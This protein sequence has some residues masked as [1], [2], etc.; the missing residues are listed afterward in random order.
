MTRILEANKPGKPEDPLYAGAVQQYQAL[1]KAAEQLRTE[2]K[3]DPMLFAL[4]H[5]LGAKPLNMQDPKEFNDELA[6]RVG[7]ART[8]SETYGAPPQLLSKD[9]ATALARGFEMASAPQQRQLLETMR[10][11]IPDDGAFTALMQQIRPDS[12]VVSYV[13]QAILNSGT[14]HVSSW[15]GQGRRYDFGDVAQLMLAGEAL[16]N[17]TKAGKAQDG[18]GTFPMPEDTLIRYQFNSMLGEAFAGSPTAANSAYQAVKAYY[19]GKSARMGAYGGKLDSG[20]LDEAIEAVLGG[21]SDLNGKGKTFRPYRM[22]EPTFQ[23]AMTDEFNAAVARN[24]YKSENFNNYGAIALG[25]DQYYLKIGNALLY[26]RD[27]TPVVVDLSK[28]QPPAPPTAGA[29]K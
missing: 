13:G 19:A 22:D 10:K 25:N 17:P 4:K 9:E 26:N 12:P 14:K 15:M 2:R 29:G 20:I 18:K 8:V 6:R 5:N 7:V 16:L 27:K 23:R 11:A 3:E 24:G 28:W 1:T 21:V